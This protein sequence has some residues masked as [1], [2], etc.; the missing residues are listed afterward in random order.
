MTNYEKIK[1]MSID[2]MATFL[3]SGD[4]ACEGCAFI[5]NPKFCANERKPFKKWLKSEASIK[6][7]A[8]K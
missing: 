2:E 8:S 5:D 4:R 6:V 7:E 1:N 3:C